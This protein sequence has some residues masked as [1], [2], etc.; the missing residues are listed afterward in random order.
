MDKLS[1]L[2]EFKL[3][4]KIADKFESD[5]EVY[6]GIGD[7]CAV[8]KKRE[9]YT[10]MTTDM[11]VEGD[12]FNLDWQTPWQI[13]WKSIIVNIS[14]IAAMGGLPKWGLV[15]IAFPGDIE[16]NFAEDIFDGMAEASEKHGM[17]IIGGDTTHGD[18]LTINV[19]VI[20]EV[21]KENLCMRGDAEIDDLICV[22]G[23]LGKS[24]AGL[25][26]LRAGKEGYTDYYLQ[27]KC[28]LKTARRIA[29][30][31]N[32]MIDVSDGLSSEVGHICD[33]SGVGAE[34]EK[35]KV[36]ISNKTRKTG[37]DLDIDP[38]KWALS[39]GEDFELVFTIPR[40]RFSKI[41]GENPVVVGKILEE[42]RYLINSE[43]RKLGRGYD[44]FDR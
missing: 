28:R 24:W 17:K 4:E 3:I 43:K 33:E 13:G 29:P 44:H 2:G 23:D 18:L 14:D 27:P 5:E 21:E 10:L 25:E 34:V 7:D 19:A 9:D 26:L 8:L 1:D 41:E 35:E 20:G 39:G 6:K 15:S 37:E 16:V 40:E 36:P 22:S 12:H 31:V 42:G 30:H 11:L 32:A 38:M